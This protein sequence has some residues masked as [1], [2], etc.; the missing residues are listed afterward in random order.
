VDFNLLVLHYG[1]HS[2]EEISGGIKRLQ[3]YGEK[4]CAFVMN[5]CE[6]EG[7]HYGYG[8]YYGKYYSK[9]KK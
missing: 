9:K 2:M 4:P 5:H 7:G 6:H 1:R 3:R 8:H